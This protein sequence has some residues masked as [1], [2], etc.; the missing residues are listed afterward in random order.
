M[1]G[2]M[3]GWMS[4]QV[5]GWAGGCLHRWTDVWV[6][7]K[8]ERDGSVCAWVDGQVMTDEEWMDE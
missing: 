4:A 6:D 7:R 5:D 8:G 1:G 2:W 3:G